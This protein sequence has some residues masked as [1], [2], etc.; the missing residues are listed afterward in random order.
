MA[1][2]R[3]D[4]PQGGV[5]LECGKLPTDVPD[6]RV[7]LVL[8]IENTYE[9]YADV[10]TYASV[11]VPAPPADEDSDAYDTWRW[12]HIIQLTGVGHPDGDSWYDITVLESSAPEV[13]P[14]GK[15]W[16]WGY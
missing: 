1:R 12:D 7:A 15:T 9:R 2:T 4:L 14:V 13:I 16:D 11:V 8:E 6:G 10:T 3:L 5:S